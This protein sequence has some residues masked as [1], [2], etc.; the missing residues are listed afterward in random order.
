[1]LQQKIISTFSKKVARPGEL[2]KFA[3]NSLSMIEDIN[4]MN[5]NLVLDLGCGTNLFK[6]KI[7]R[8]VGVDILNKDEDVVCP[9]EDLDSI[10]QPNCADVVLALG[11]INFGDD[12]LITKQLEQTKKVTKP[13]GLIYF[14]VNPKASHEIYYEWNFDKI[15][16]YT[17]KMNF[18][19]KVKPTII[20]KAKEN[21]V[22]DSPID[23]QLNRAPSSTRIFLVWRKLTEH[24]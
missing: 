5:P 16:T 11:S 13:G 8:L 7:N 3:E 17:K 19:Y 12:D 20:T 9:I 23:K 21:L 14:R 1:M 4:A 2:I 24:V 22:D 18:E 6:N 15:E 10:F